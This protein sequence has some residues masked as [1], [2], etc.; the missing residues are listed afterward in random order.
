MFI[1]QPQPQLLDAFIFMSVEAYSEFIV[2]A[3]ESG[4]HGL[5]R[6]DAGFPVFVLACCLFRK[7]AYINRLVPGLHGFKFRHFGHD[8]VILHERDIRKDEGA[9]AMLKSPER[10]ELFLEELT[11]IVR[12]TPMEVVAAV[13]RKD[14]LLK[15]HGVKHHPYH[16]SLLFCLERLLRLLEHSGQAGRPTHVTCEARGKEEDL[17]LELAFRR[18]RDGDNSTGKR[19]PFEVVIAD[20]KVNCAGLQLADLIAR[21]IGLS[22]TRPAQPNRAFEVIREKLARDPDGKIEQWGLA[23]FP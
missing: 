6:V 18:I 22:V 16:L 3:D 23:C 8:G 19:L 20:K 11:E 2:Y 7:N 12:Q 15:Q 17:Q 21:P 9:F 5:G 13:I 4:D 10:K 14:Q 1:S